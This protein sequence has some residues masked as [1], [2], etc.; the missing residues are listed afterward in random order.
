MK[1]ASVSRRPAIRYASASVAAVCDGR[2]PPVELLGERDRAVAALHVLRAERLVE[3]AVD[4]REDRVRLAG[5]AREGHPE[6]GPAE[7][8][9]EE[10]ERARRDRLLGRGAR[11]LPGHVR[12]PRRR[13]QGGEHVATGEALAEK[14]Q[15]DAQGRER[16]VVRDVV[17][18]EEPDDAG[19]VRFRREGREGPALRLR[20]DARPDR[21][22]VP[23]EDRIGLERAERVHGHAEREQG[24]ERD[25][26]RRARREDRGRGEE[27]DE[28]DEEPGAPARRAVP[29]PPRGRRQE[30]EGREARDR[31][32]EGAARPR[33]AHE[34][35]DAPRSARG[36]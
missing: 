25:R 23:R 20:Q 22:V 31:E 30:E 28:R 27:G 3:Q 26:R 12:A 33:E 18:R 14:P 15:V 24:R 19:R 16:R 8:R 34:A 32:T 21:R 9:G 5:A 35:A 4:P 2:D 11:L 13:A 6:M 17:D 29:G 1:S 10:D 7:R 36:K